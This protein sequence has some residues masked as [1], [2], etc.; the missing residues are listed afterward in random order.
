MEIKKIIFA[1][2]D[3]YFLEFWPIQ[4][5]LCRELFGWEPVLFKISNEESDFYNDG[6]GLV[7]KIK[8]VQGIHT[9]LQACTVRMFGTKYFPDDVCICGDLDM[10]MINKNYFDQHFLVVKQVI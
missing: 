1:S 3:S 9:A 7:K 2:D 6:N 5:K 8:S 4:A 10:L